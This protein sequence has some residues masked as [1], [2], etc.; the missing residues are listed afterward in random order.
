MICSTTEIGL[1]KLNDGI[2]ELD[3]SIGELILGKDLNEYGILNDDIIEI[4]LTANRGD[5][6]SIHGVAREIGAYYGIACIDSEKEEN[7]NDIGIGQVFELSYEG[8]IDSDVVYKAYDLENFTMPMITKLRAGIIDKFDEKNNTKTL[9]N[10]ITHST[11]VILNAYSKENIQIDDKA[12]LT[13]SKDQYG[14]DIIKNGENTMS[15][16][17]VDLNDTKP[18]DEKYIIEASYINPDLLSKKVFETK[19]ETGDVYYRSSRGSEPDLDFGLEYLT[20]FISKNNGFVYNSFKS[21]IEETPENIIDVNI[22]KVNSIIGQ[23]VTKAEIEN[24]LT[25]LGFDVKDNN[26]EVLAV[27]VPKYRHDIVNIADITEE[28]VRMIGIDNIKSKPLKIDEV[29][30]NNKTSADL[31]K[32]NRLRFKAIENGFYETLTYVFSSKESLEKY[33]FKTVK[34][35]LDILNPIVKELNTFRSTILL[36][37]VEACSSNFKNG[38]RSNSFFE[39]G[40]I[41]DENRNESKMISFVQTGSIEQ[42]D[43]TNS[44]KPQNIDFFAFAKKILNTV[45]KFDL[46]PMQNITNDFIHPYQ[47]ADVIVNGKVIGFISKLHPSVSEDYDL[48]D[49]FIAEINFDEIKNDLITTQKYSKFQSSKKDLSIL[50]SKDMPYK[51]IKDAINSLNNQNIKQFN[52]I[53]VYNDENLGDNESITIRFVLQNDNKTLEEKDITTTMDAI[54]EVLN[55]KLDIQIR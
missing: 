44:G 6:L 21:N 13:V 26:E 1:P 23:I 4:E 24:I 28:I 35:E 46:E 49:T 16:I 34:E 54:L 48:S 11:G 19:T 31:Q 53:D 9:L 42:E 2:L 43:I 18:N 14:F 20:S 50:V 45:G 29:N 5:C 15:T 10:Y 27:T 36:N 7:S 39:I 25:S 3:D 55:E 38:I 41:F 12:S 51:N 8:T 37:L 40:T 17:G 52:L 33:S 47:N 22:R 30:R 32:K